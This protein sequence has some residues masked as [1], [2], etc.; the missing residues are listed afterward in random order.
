LN[1]VCLDF[2]NA[3][4]LIWQPLPTIQLAAPN[5]DLCAGDCRTL[6]VL[7][8]GTGAFSVTGNLVSGGNVVGTFNETFGGNTGTISLCVPGGTPP[9]PVLVQPTVLTDA[10]CICE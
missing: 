4:E 1:D 10:W 8:S 2:S 7:L 9:G 6:E 5:P 3:L